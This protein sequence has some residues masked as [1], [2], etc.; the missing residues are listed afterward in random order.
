MKMLRRLLIVSAGIGVSHTAFSQM[1]VI[2]DDVPAA[3]LDISATGTPLHPT[4]DGTVDMVT[5][6]SNALF[7]AG[8]WRVGNNGGMALMPPPGAGLPPGPGFPVSLPNP[9]VF[10]G[11]T[12]AILPAWDDPGDAIGN[13]YWQ[14]F[15]EMLVVQ[16]DRN[17]NPG[18]TNTTSFQA[19]V[20]A[21]VPLRCGVYAQF[22]YRNV[23][24]LPR[25]NFGAIFTIGYQDSDGGTHGSVTWEQRPIT[26]QTVLSLSCQ[27]AGCIADVDDGSGTGT[28]DGGVTL[29]DL[30]YYLNL[31][32]A[33]DSRADVDNGSGLGFPDGGIGIE[34]L[35]FFLHRFDRGC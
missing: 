10:G 12:Q 5:T 8:T 13:V 7:P 24:Q 35:L 11:S 9:L 30:L 22:L 23:Q 32:D 19:R 25:P 17:L 1:L 3:F 6:I 20:N 21:G 4:D 34:D 14:E 18:T 2:R 15:P 16:W 29:D 26:N 28:P 31:F 33:G 27:P